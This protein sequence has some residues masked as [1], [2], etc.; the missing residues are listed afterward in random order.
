MTVYRQE[1]VG[2][3]SFI[4]LLEEAVLRRSTVAV[5]LKDGSTFIDRVQD[6]ATD[7]G[8]EWAVFEEHETVRTSEI[9][10]MTRG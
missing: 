10:S 1:E 5:H 7:R 8:A 9:A 2:S 3:C 4:D 6:V